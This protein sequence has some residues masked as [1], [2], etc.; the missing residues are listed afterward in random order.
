MNT[1]YTL[2]RKANRPQAALDWFKKNGIAANSVNKIEVRNEGDTTEIQV[3]GSIGKSWWDDSGISEQEFRNALDQIPKGKS[4]TVKINSE[5]GSV[6][7]GLGIYNAIKDRSADVTCIIQGYAL[8]IASVFPLAASRVISPKAAI[9]MIHC[10]WSYAQGNAADMRKSADM[11]DAHDET[12]MDIYAAKT[13]KSKAELRASMEKET[14]IKGADAVA[15]GLADET[16]ADD[17][18]DTLAAGK[19]DTQNQATAAVVAKSNPTP[20]T[21]AAKPSASTDAEKQ[22]AAVLPAATNQQPNTP[23]P[24]NTTAAASTPANQTDVLATVQAQLA[25]ER[26]ARIT[27]LVTR[28]AENKI[29]NDNLNWWIEAAMKD[30]AGVVAQIEAMPA[31][32][33][34]ADPLGGSRIE[35]GS[36]DVLAGYSGKPSQEIVNLFKEHKTPEARYAALKRDWREIHAAA[37]KRDGGVMNAN[38]YSATLTTNFLIMGATTKLSPKFAALQAFSRDVSVDPYK[39]LATGVMK[40]TS[41]LQDGSTVQTNATNFESSTQQVDAVS[42]S[43]NQYTNGASITNSDLNSGIRMEDIQR[44][45]LMG[46]GSKVMQVV[47]APATT[48]NFTATPLT[49]ALNPGSFGFA[50]SRQLYATLKFANTRNL[51]LDTE[52]TAGLL[53]QPSYFQKALEQQTGPGH[54][55]NVF[56][57][58]NVYEN[59]EWS[60]AGVNVHGFACDPQ[61]IGVIA[62]LPL[63]NNAGIPGGILSVSTG[64]IPGAEL[65][66]AAYLW[67]STASRTYWMSYDVMVG[68]AKLDAT[69]GVIIKSGA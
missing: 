25:A 9:W 14:W 2:A 22:T 5:G 41:S 38:T 20:V 46:L 24:E 62:G 58:D 50:E 32:V 31:A 23:M 49:A 47:L 57:W 19:R 30:E 33:V 44:A 51:I 3:I 63:T 17:A 39:P 13:G 37:L 55:T 12:L 8:S 54:W 16:D 65:P 7:D 52:Y 18:D 27:D 1:T 4:V 66:I 40:F 53:N 64:I 61:A 35:V 59:T 29:K 45:A 60:G 68:A 42:I 67:F 21:P 6:Q 48:T 56:G 26:K 28:K 36:G 10:A 69:A 15:W 34:A 43:V 11:L